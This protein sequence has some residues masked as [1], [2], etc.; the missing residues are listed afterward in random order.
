MVIGVHVMD[1]N[2]LL[3]DREADE[4]SGYV[5]VAMDEVVESL[6]VGNG[7]CQVCT[8]PTIVMVEIN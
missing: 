7:C 5:V 4:G 2:G 6:P 3:L 8:R 1:S